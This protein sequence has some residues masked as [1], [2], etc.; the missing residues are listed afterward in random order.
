MTN[1][2]FLSFLNYL[3][4]IRL[5]QSSF[6]SL[7]A[8]YFVKDASNTIIILHTHSLMWKER[9][10]IGFLQFHTVSYVLDADLTRLSGKPYSICVGATRAFKTLS[11]ISLTTLSSLHI[12]VIAVAEWERKIN[13]TQLLQ[14]HFYHLASMSSITVVT[15][16]NF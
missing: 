3:N 5:W 8:R 13:L 16:M 1:F 7:V 15:W 4:S 11:L 2:K 10:R 6:A 12:Y 14:L 9:R